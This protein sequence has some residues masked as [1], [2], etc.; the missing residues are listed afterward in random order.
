M[1]GLDIGYTRKC[2]GYYNS[3]ISLDGETDLIASTLW[4]HIPPSEA[5]F[6]EHGVA[7]F[8]VIRDAS[9]QYKSKSLT[10]KQS[11]RKIRYASLIISI[12]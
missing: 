10:F 1:R 2:Q 11:G 9:F 4:A 5:Y 3:V 6:T 7:D 12:Q 8:R